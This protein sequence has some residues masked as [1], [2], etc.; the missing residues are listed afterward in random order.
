MEDFRAIAA[1]LGRRGGKASKRPP[2]ALRRI[3]L[4]V[5]EE[6]GSTENRDVFRYWQTYET[7]D[8]ADNAPER[9]CWFCHGL[10]AWPLVSNDP[11]NAYILKM[12]P[13]PDY[14]YTYYYFDGKHEQETD[15]HRIRQTLHR[16]RKANKRLKETSPC[17]NGVRG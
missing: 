7:S 17:E 11:G 3:L 8:R 5:C 15:A 1:T 10:Y 9:N 4:E 14:K 6:V 16:I 13:V 2:G 12:L